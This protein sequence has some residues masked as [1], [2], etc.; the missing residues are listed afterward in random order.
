[1]KESQQKSQDMLKRAKAYQEAAQA[2][3][4]AVTSAFQ[5]TVNHVQT[6]MQTLSAQA[7]RSKEMLD[8]MSSEHK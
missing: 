4:A 6:T 1:M 5:E 2:S 8:S 7:Q 3:S